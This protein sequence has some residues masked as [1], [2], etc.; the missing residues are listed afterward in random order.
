MRLTLGAILVLCIVS[1]AR[2]QYSLDTLGRIHPRPGTG[3]S[4][5]WGYT[6]PDGREY[7]LVGI[8]GSGSGSTSGGTSIVD[9]TDDHNPRLVT[10][11]VGPNSSWR[12]IKT[13][14]HYAYVVTEAGGGTQI[15]DLSQLPDTA[16]L[17]RSFTYTQG[18][19]NTGRAHTITITDG[20]MY[21]NGCANWGTVTN[22]KGTQIF[23]LREDPENP[24]FLSD[25][26]PAYFHDLYVLR[27]TIYAS[28]IYGGG[29][30]FIADA[31]NKTGVQTIAQISY[32]NSGTHN[33]W[34]TKDRRYI[35]T[36]D[37]I[38]H[39]QKDLKIWD[40]GNLPSVPTAPTATFTV[41]PTSTIHNVHVRGDFAYCSWYNGYALQIVDV[42]NP[43]VPVLAAGYAITGSGLSWDVY[44]YFPSGRII[45]GAGSTGLWI[46][47]FSGL[48]PRV[49]VALLSPSDH[50]TITPGNSITFRWTK[51]ADL[52]K[53]PHYYELHLSGP[54]VDTMWVSNDSVASLTDLSI[55]SNGQEYHWYIVT[56]DEWNTTMSPQTFSFI[57]D[58]TTG[59]PTVVQTP[60]E[61][62]LEQNYPNPFNPSTTIG[63]QLAEPGQVVL[64]VYNVLGQQVAELV[65]TYQV[66]GSYHIHFDTRDVTAQALASGVYLYR[67]SA[68]GYIETRRMVLAR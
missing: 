5:V 9:I 51:S 52:D 63:Y 25:Y 8:S 60:A 42:T 18:S 35:L 28:A 56:R 34:L 46:F 2:G 7:A 48:Q 45:I 6:A 50:E 17:V 1:S 53:D 21:L 30:V 31:R 41:N 67:L 23:D 47:R 57:Y 16:R 29:G 61:F 20:F 59:A 62:Q 13:Y 15:I 11:I 38:T 22:E 54:G 32:A 27:D 36:T 64:R 43:P 68:G 40:I 14:K 24:V 4:A 65:N 49:P 10:H 33:A 26:S 12:E 66:S 44:P 39:P 19:K 55:L 37:E 3:L 58:G